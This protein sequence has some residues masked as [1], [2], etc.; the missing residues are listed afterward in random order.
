[1]KSIRKIFKGII[2]L[3]CDKEHVLVPGGIRRSFIVYDLVNDTVGLCYVFYRYPA[4]H[5]LRHHISIDINKPIISRDQ[6]E[7][8]RYHVC[9]YHIRLA[10]IIIV[11]VI[12]IGVPKQYHILWTER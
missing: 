1:M 7:V 11:S 9:W 5:H 12:V 8:A 10:K 3:I 4:D 6:T 2:I